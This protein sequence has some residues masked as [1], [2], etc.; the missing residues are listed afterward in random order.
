M[1][2]GA[3]A[4][5]GRLELSFAVPITAVML[6]AVAG[7]YWLGGRSAAGSASPTTAAAAS[8]AV[9]MR[10][11]TAP[12][13]L[14]GTVREQADRL[15]ERIM[16]AR[17][18]GD[19]EEVR[20]FLPMALTAYESVPDLDADGLFHLGILQVEA[21]RAAAAAAAGNDILERDPGHLFGI[22]LQAQASL[23]AG[24]SAEASAFFTRYL[25]RFDEE[26]GRNLEE[27]GVHRPA[28][29]EYRSQALALT[30]R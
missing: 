21:G 28:L 22:L 26:L 1:Q 23:V 6:L 30:G 29:D 14:T 25:D 7:A 19:D 5:T 20:F 16:Q 10:S 12:P 8:P 9:A 17:A 4:R 24:D 27:Y 13:P 11:T 18:R 15:F 3:R 2:C